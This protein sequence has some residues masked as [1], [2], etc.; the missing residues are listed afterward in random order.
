VKNTAIVERPSA[1]VAVCAPVSAV[2]LRSPSTSVVRD[3]VAVH[4]A[5]RGTATADAPQ[6][7]QV[8]QIQVQ[9][10]LARTMVPVSGSY[11]INGSTVEG[12]EMAAKKRLFNVARGGVP[13]R[14]RPV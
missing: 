7:P 14:G 13:P 6:L 1:L 12:T 8:H 5:G 2:W 10:E 11:G 4:R 3:A 9:A